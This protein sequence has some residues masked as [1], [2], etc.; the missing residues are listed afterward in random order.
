VAHGTEINVADACHGNIFFV[1]MPSHI[2]VLVPRLG[3]C[4]DSSFVSYAS[5]ILSGLM[6]LVWKVMRVQ[7]KTNGFRTVLKEKVWLGTYHTLINA[8][9]HH[10]FYKIVL[11]VEGCIFTCLNVPTCN[12]PLGKKKTHKL[13]LNFG[14]DEL[15]ALLYKAVKYS[16]MWN[17]HKQDAERYIFRNHTP[18]QVRSMLEDLIITHCSELRQHIVKSE[19]VWNPIWG[20]FGMWL[21]SLSC[22]HG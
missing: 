4:N 19:V 17:N 2:A 21:A 18:E 7:D 14:L 12:Q 11:A 1:E 22:D 9:V 6:Q 8:A 15:P 5:H 16:K 13:K 10:D 20:S 3:S